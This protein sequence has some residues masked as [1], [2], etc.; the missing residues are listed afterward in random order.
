MMTFYLILVLLPILA[1]TALLMTKRGTEIKH[2]LHFIITGLESGFR[3]QQIVFLGKIAS[4]TG[5]ENPTQLFWSVQAL[6]RCT[7]EIVRRTR[8]TATENDPSTQSLLSGLYAYRT[9][10]ELDQSK[11]KRGLDS[12][13][14]IV[15]NQKIRI[16]LRGVGV[17]SSRVLRVTAKTLVVDFPSGTK[18]PATSIKWQGKAVS[19]FFWRHED[20]GYVFESVVVPDPVSEGKAVIHLTHSDSL[21]R[22]QKR[23]SVRVKCSV[24]AQMYLVKPN[25]SLDSSLEPE[26][27]M[28]CLLE[29]LSEDGAMIIIGGKA[30]RDMKIKL[31]FMIHDVLIVMAGTVRAVEFN[32]DTNQSRM[33][34][35]C[36]ELNPRMKNAV[37]TFVYNVLPEEEKEELDAIRLTEEDGITDAESVPEAGAEQA[38]D[39]DKD[40]I[41][42]IDSVER[43]TDLPDFAGKIS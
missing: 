31:Q 19:V 5:L 12:T 42:T 4:T 41:S 24:Y 2:Y 35:E 43:S 37:L 29:D 17:F 40:G 36:G 6:D 39:G 28:K 25:E 16:L 23:K 3:L 21:V 1:L 30:V 18:I 9:K 11:K 33:H 15:V 26:P 32:R 22:S 7:A 20:A 34:F 8:Q 38:G 10:I 27:G 13:R 14:D